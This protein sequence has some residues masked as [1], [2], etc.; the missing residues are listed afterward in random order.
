MIGDCPDPVPGETG[1]LAIW[2]WMHREELAWLADQASRMDSVVEVGS[3]HGRSAYALLDACPGLVYCIDPWDDDHGYGY[4]SFMRSC[5]HFVNLVTV[6]GY[7]PAVAEHLPSVDMVFIDGAHDAASVR[8][9]I[10]AW[11]PKTRKL[12]CGHDFYPGEDAG[13]PDVASVTLEVFGDALRIARATSI[14]YVDVSSA[15]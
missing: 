11:L 4:P 7:S 13:Y 6:K 14:W 15:K 12:I 5:G 8:A 1:A 10:D 9:D 2:G 3:L